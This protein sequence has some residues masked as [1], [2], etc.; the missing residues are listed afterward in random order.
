MFA[1]LNFDNFDEI[2][3]YSNIN[4]NYTWILLWIFKFQERFRASDVAI[5]SLIGF[6]SLVLNEADL[7]KF[8]DFPST[9]YMARKILEI[10]KNHKSFTVCSDCNKLYNLKDILPKDQTRFDEF[11]CTH[12]EISESSNV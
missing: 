8:K 11:K 12:I 1:T 3:T 2:S 6:L 7:Y 10:N 4:Y 9:C 5:N